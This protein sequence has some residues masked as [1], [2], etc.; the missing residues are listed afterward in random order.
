MEEHTYE[1]FRQL[2]KDKLRKNLAKWELSE[3]D[4]EKYMQQEEDQIKGAH[5]HYLNPREND[6][7]AD[8]VRF[9]IGASTIAYCL[10][11]CY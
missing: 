2:V 4:L 5:N 8:D 1:K 6:T 3:E 10:E 9:D 11:M 7:R